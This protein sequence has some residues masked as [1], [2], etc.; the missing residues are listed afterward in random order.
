MQFVT[1]VSLSCKR[2]ENEAP[3]HGFGGV[4]DVWCKSRAVVGD[5]ADDDDARILFTSDDVCGSAGA[6]KGSLLSSSSSVRLNE[7]SSSSSLKDSIFGVGVSGLSSS[8]CCGCWVFLFDE[9]VN[10]LN[11]AGKSC[12]NSIRKVK[13]KHAALL[14]YSASWEWNGVVRNLLQEDC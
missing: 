6:I 5:A 12:A 1:S 4:I 14:T 7:L 13:W 2:C 9:R 10:L 11:S 8:L 3:S